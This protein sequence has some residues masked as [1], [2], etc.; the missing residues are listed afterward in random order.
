MQKRRRQPLF[1]IIMT[2]ISALTPMI[3]LGYHLRQNQRLKQADPAAKTR[4]WF[5]GTG[6]TPFNI[7]LNLD[8]SLSTLVFLHFAYQ[9]VKAG[10]V[11]GPFWLYAALNTFVGLSPAFPFLLLM[12]KP[13]GEQ[14]TK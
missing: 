2:V 13:E 5:R 3:L 12:R 11:K 10:R 8:L 6:G 9:E 14:P 4:S 1:E 7:A